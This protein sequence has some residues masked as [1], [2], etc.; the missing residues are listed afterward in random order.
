MRIEDLG[1][2]GFRLAEGWVL[3][4]DIGVPAWGYRAV[5]EYQFDEL[6]LLHIEH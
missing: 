3:G 1:C 5:V 2:I 4:Q 6:A